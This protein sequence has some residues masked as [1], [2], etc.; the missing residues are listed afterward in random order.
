[1][2]TP[3]HTSFRVAFIP[4]LLLAVTGGLP[5]CTWVKTTPEGEKVTVADGTGVSNCERKGEVESALKSRVA[6]VER[7]ATKVAGELEALARNEAAKMGGDTIVAES[8]V[9]DGKKT[10]GVYRCRS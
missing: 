2:H 5:A 4:V 8:N 10:Y 6:G 3:L 7:N 1:L 9:R